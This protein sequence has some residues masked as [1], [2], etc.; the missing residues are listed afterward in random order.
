MET[1]GE[2]LMA[3]INKSSKFWVWPAGQW[4][5]VVFLGFEESNFKWRNGTSSKTVRY[6]FRFEDGAEKPIDVQSVAFA[7]LMVNYK[8]GDRL[9]IRRDKTAG[10]K[11]EYQV[12]QA[13]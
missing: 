6:F 1:N 9:R 7:K 3:Y 13:E 5:E 12:S 2:G 4:H 11:Y 10:Q 8:A